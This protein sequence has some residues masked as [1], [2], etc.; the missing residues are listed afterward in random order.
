MKV[1]CA[2]AVV[3]VLAGSAFAASVATRP[4]TAVVKRATV[5]SVAQL[6]QLKLPTLRRVMKAGTIPAAIGPVQAMPMGGNTSTASAAYRTGDGVVLRPN[7]LC[8][9]ATGSFSVLTFVQLHDSSR[10]TICNPACTDPL[11]LVIPPTQQ[12]R[13]GFCWARFRSIASGLHTYVATLCVRPA[14]GAE[15]QI[16]SHLWLHAGNEVYAGDAILTN[17]AT[18]D[19]RV[20]FAYD[21]AAAGVDGVLDVSATWNHDVYS[22]LSI[23]YIQLAQLD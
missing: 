20:M 23:Y 5:Y 9:E 11:M 2:V 1:L 16:L 8:H 10:N 3:L 7:S 15:V 22:C 17:P 21:P 18:G 14:P 12:N 4:A 13:Y 19:Y 6:R